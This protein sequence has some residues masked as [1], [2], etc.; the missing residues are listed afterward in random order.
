MIG[1]TFERLKAQG[2]CALVTYVTAGDPSLDALPEVLSLLEAAGAD[3][4]E[5]GIPFSDPIAD[6]PTIQ[7]SSQ[8]A[9]D[10]GVTP[11]MVLQALAQCSVK[12]PIVLMGYLN[13]IIRMGL[14]TFKQA[15]K[16]S[17]AHG[18]IVCDVTPEDAVEWINTANGELETIFLA[19]PTSTDD[20][21]QRVAQA[22]SGFI[23]A[24]ARTGVTGHEGLGESGAETLV[25]R[26]RTISNK[27]IAVGFGISTPEHVA[28]V[29]RFA[30]GAIVGSALVQ[31][32]ADTWTETDGPKN[33]AEYVRSLK[34]ATTTS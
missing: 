25:T 32:I 5:V 20:R 11:T 1:Q 2:Q 4:I 21:L 7:A 26:L 29:C 23:Y 16:D 3:I 13:P 15:A 19:A 6:G 22:A 12:V 14:S 18:V 24:V 17:G 34:A 27:P 33:I 10:R 31:R 9:L 30:D 8:R 28:D